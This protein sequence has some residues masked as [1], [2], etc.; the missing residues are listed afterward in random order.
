[1][2]VAVAPD[3]ELA[4]LEQTTFDDTP[5]DAEDAATLTKF[6]EEWVED[7]APHQIKCDYWDKCDRAYLGEITRTKDQEDEVYPRYL[8]QNAEALVANM[9]DERPKSH[10]IP[11]NNTKPQQA[12][13]FEKVLAYQEQEDGYEAELISFFRQGVIRGSSALKSAWLVDKRRVRQRTWAQD[14]SENPSKIVTTYH[15]RA[16]TICVDVKDLIVDSR[17]TTRRNVRRVFYV[18]YSTMAELEENPNYRNLDKVRL[19]NREN[20]TAAG[21]S[22]S[23][24][25]GS[26]RSD[27]P[28][29]AVSRR[30]LHKVVERWDD[31]GGLVAVCDDKVVI[32]S[33][34]GPFDHGMIPFD[35]AMPTPEMFKM[36]GISLMAMLSDVQTA[37][38]RLL[39]AALENADAMA[40]FV[41][42]YQRDSIRKDDLDLFPGAKVGV[43]QMGAFEPFRPPTEVLTASQAMIGQLKGEMQTVSP[44]NPYVTGAQNT[45][46]DN[47]TATGISL[48]QS[49]SQKLILLMKRSMMLCVEGEC[50]KRI[51]LNKQLLDR[52]VPILL[53]DKSGYEYVGPE[54]I[55]GDYDFIV[56]DVAESLNQQQQRADALAKA[57]AL[58]QLNAAAVMMPGQPPGLIDFKPVAQDIAEAFGD[59]PDKYLN[60]AAGAAPA[61][62][63]GGAPLP[64]LPPPPD[65][66]GLLALAGSGGGAPPQAPVA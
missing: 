29:D 45:G 14:G 25:I 2:A 59:P 41:L 8:W 48:I 63:T 4:T 27:A 43:D 21:E 36:G 54:E 53:G 55:Q 11:R 13:C 57:Q 62:Q 24:R 28:T 44:A 3:D 42:F 7:Y 33:G 17:A 23:Q 18:T 40:A 30:G 38:W 37:L 46:I 9:I 15:P 22:N 35:W 12:K 10:L 39:N 56:E 31:R 61:S 52:N 34:A 26:S 6:L 65:L 66:N 5:T 49:A 64:P 47:R 60:S 51:A 1:M 19:M 50:R 20:A 16:T 58:S 32:R